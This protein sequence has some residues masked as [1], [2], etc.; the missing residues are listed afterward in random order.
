MSGVAMKNPM[1]SNSTA[2]ALRDALR[3]A[4]RRIYDPLGVHISL[5][6]SQETKRM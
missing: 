4:L 5:E 1:F 2:E 3:D 6:M